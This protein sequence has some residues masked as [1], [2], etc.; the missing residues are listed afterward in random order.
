MD[1]DDSI[2]LHHRLRTEEGSPSL[3]IAV[4]IEL[5]K[6]SKKAYHK[7]GNEDPSTGHA[8][9][10]TPE[11]DKWA[12]YEMEV[13]EKSGEL[14]DDAEFPEALLE[15]GESFGYCELYSRSVDTMLKEIPAGTTV[16]LMR[17]TDGTF[18]CT[19]GQSGEVR[20]NSASTAM[21]LAFC[22]HIDKQEPDETNE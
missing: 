14:P 12:K 6:I 19:I 17:Q 20:T 11:Y 7:E 9:F 10:S 3:D 13:F 5:G 15:A 8:V 4:A 1:T 16:N 21:A 22:R 18:L 2:T